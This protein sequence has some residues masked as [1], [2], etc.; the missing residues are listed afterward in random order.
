MRVLLVTHYYPEHRSGVE[1][2]AGE[3]ARRLARRGVDI[4]WAASGLAAGS[5]PDGVT[6]LPMRASNLTEQRFGF[7]YPFWGPLS[8]WRL[9]R[10]VRRCD[11]VHLHDSLY[12]GNV[13]AFLYARRYRKPVVVTQHIGHVPYSRWA[14]RALLG[15]AN[16]TL[17]RLVLGGCQRSVFISPQVLGYFRPRLRFR[18]PPLY[19]PNGVDTATFHPATAEQ[20]RALRD[21]LGWAA[22]RRVLLFV[23]RFVEKKGLGLLRRLAEQVTGCDWAFVGWGPDDPAGWGLPNVRCVGT[24]PHHEI[25]AYYRAADLLVLPSVGEGFPLVVQEAMACGLPA[26]ISTETVQ[27]APDVESVVYTADLE[28]E[29]W[30]EAIRR[31]D[32]DPTALEARRQQVADFARRWDW[33]SCAARYVQLFH[34]A[35][36]TGP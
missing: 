7:P 3:V 31:L 28:P 25:P 8:L 23:G 10:E 33:D 20:R 17:A 1:I 9:G 6:R 12:L 15:L 19:L 29:A 32:W 16:R 13:A 26:L 24:L 36:G 14:L 22:D 27:G 18:T 5:G 4:V 35:V 30:A 11:V 2:V 34:E 21:R